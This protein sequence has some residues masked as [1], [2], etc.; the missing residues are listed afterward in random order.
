MTSAELKK[1][2]GDKKMLIGATKTVAEM[3][4][5]N[6]KK[7]FLAANCDVKTRATIES[8]AKVLSVDVAQVEVSS[9]E[10]GVLVKKPFSVSV[11]SLSK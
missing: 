8:N 5:G 4:K 2:V 10:M 3:K 1:V 9:E 6:V 7:I 11:I